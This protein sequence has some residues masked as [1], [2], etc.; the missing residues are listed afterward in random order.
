MQFLRAVSD[1][2][3]YAQPLQTT[4][5]MSLTL[6]TTLTTRI[7][8]TP[9]LRPPGPSPP[10]Q[11]LLHMLRVAKEVYFDATFKIVPGIC[12]QLLRVFAACGDNS[13]CC[14]VCLLQ[15]RE[16]VALVPCGHSRFCG[17]CADTVASLDVLA[18]YAAWCCVC[19][20]KCTLS[21]Q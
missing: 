19:M 1:G 7:P 17:S 2:I 6:P 11:S 20:A 8:R 21:G 9:R 10:L 14:E 13:D 5:L 15:P 16:G 3:M 18:R 12:Y 4:A